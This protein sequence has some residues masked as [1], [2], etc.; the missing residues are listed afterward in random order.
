MMVGSPTPNYIAPSFLVSSRYGRPGNSSSDLTFEV[1]QK[2]CATYQEAGYP[3]GRWRLPT[4]AEVYFLFTLQT[5]RLI[6]DLYTTG[7]NT[8]G[9]WA[10][11]RYVFGR[12]W[13]TGTPDFR[14]LNNGEAAS[15]RCVYDT[16]FWGEEPDTRDTYHPGP[17]FYNN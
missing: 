4:E 15:I 7:N 8:Y 11:S 14:T 10:S 1:A 3:A 12:N 16:W 5:R 13:T 9:Y 6:T 17:T 2:R